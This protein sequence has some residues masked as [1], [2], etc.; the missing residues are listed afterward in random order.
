M[1]LRL[2]L[3]MMLAFAAPA[4]PV[5]ACHE[6]PAMAMTQHEMDGTRHRS[7]A[8]AEHLCVGCTAMADWNAMR[9]TPPILLPAPMPVASTA[10]PTLLPAEAPAPPP[11]KA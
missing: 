7:P 2:L 8:Q 5:A 3:V 6:A 4:M 9:I 1:L 10:A 11:P